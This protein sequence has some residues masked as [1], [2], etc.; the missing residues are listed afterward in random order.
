MENKTKQ[1]PKILHMH[2]KS[3]LTQ[4]SNRMELNTILPLIA[5]HCRLGLL[6]P[7]TCTIVCVLETNKIQ[8]EEKLA[9]DKVSA[10]CSGAW[11]AVS[12]DRGNDQPVEGSLHLYNASFKRLKEYFFIS[13]KKPALTLQATNKINI[14][15]VRKQKAVILKLTYYANEDLKYI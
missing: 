3:L 5:L 2:S 1:T 10:S 7:Y 14:K 8:N 12:D 11:Q 15:K 13:R 4:V 9:F 6:I